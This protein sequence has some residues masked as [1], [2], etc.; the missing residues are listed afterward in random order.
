MNFSD[1]SENQNLID[2]L[3]DLTLHSYSAMN[4]ILT[5]LIFISKTRKPKCKIILCYDSN[6]LVAWALSS[7]ESCSFPF[8]NSSDIFSYKKDGLLF[9]VFVKPSYRR[10]GIGSKFMKIAQKMVRTKPICVC[11]WDSRSSSFYKKFESMNHKKL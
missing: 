8:M 2:K 6:I 1:I 5:D 4:F 3:R 7:K 9:Q 11:P 10:K